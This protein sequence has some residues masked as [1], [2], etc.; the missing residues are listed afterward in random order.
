[1]SKIRMSIL[2]LITLALLTGQATVTDADAKVRVKVTLQTPD[3]RVRISN[4]SS[5][6][7]RIYKTRH[8]PVRVNIHYR[9]NQQDREIAR[10]LGRYADVPPRELMQLRRQGYRWPEIGRWLYLP[11][12]VVRAAMHQQSWNRFLREERRLA[13]CDHDPYRGRI[14]VD[15]DN[16]Y[17]DD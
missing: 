9:I 3:A 11:R 10:R 17:Y 15:A 7:Q 4:T 5:S 1:M 13:S 16:G 8:L 12:P 6:H 2:S 14:M